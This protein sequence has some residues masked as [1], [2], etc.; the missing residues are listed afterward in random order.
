MPAYARVMKDMIKVLPSTAQ[1]R[2]TDKGTVIR[3]AFYRDFAGQIEDAYRDYSS[4]EALPVIEGQELLA[5]LRQLLADI[6]LSNSAGAEVKDDTV[7]FSLGIDSLQSLRMRMS[8]MK[9][10]N[11]AGASLPQNFV[12]E[13][14]SLQAMASA[15][16][17]LRLGQEAELRRRGSATSLLPVSIPPPPAPV[18]QRP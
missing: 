2:T 13:N 16:T 7:L 5:H 11:L 3:S 4:N 12:F 15:L 14:P 17:R 8:I 6:V 10:I 1:Y 18:T 9:T